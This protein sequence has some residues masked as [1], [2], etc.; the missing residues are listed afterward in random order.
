MAFTRALSFDKRQK[1][2]SLTVIGLNTN[3]ENLS[4][5]KECFFAVKGSWRFVASKMIY[6]MAKG[7][8]VRA[9]SRP[10]IL[11][12]QFEHRVI[13]IDGRCS[14]TNNESKTIG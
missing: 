8:D 1:N 11:T 7:I 6:N 12:S 4:V 9:L 14:I 3:S 2:T 5:V 10:L 13:D